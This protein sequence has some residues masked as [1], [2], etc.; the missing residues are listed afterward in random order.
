[1]DKNIYEKI[2]KAI[3]YESYH[4]SYSPMFSNIG[5]QLTN[6]IEGVGSLYLNYNRSTRSVF[7]NLIS[8]AVKMNL[9]NSTA[10]KIIFGQNEASLAFY[11]IDT[12]LFESEKLD[13]VLLFQ[14]RSENTLDL[15][16]NF[17]DDILFINGYSKNLDERD[18]DEKVGF[19]IAAK[20]IEGDLQKDT[21][22]S[23]KNK[24]KIAFTVQILE[25]NEETLVSRLNEAPNTI[26]EAM[27]KCSKWF[28]DNLKDFDI[29]L[30]TKEESDAI[31]SAV[32]GLL[33]NCTKAPGKLRNHIS[34][35]PNRGQYPTH[36]IWDS[37]FQ[38]LAYECINK[39]IAKDA[40]LQI[41]E[42]QRPDGKYPQFMC[43]TWDRPHDSQ[44]ALLGWAMKR[45]ITIIE[46]DVEFEKKVFLSMEKNNMWWLTQ[47]M[48]KYGV[49][50]CP[51]GLETGQDN[52]PRFDN[53]PTL[54]TDM[55]SFLLHQLKFTSETAL[56]FGF[57]EKAKYWENKA[58]KLEEN[59][60]KMLY[61]EEYNLFFDY[62]LTKNEP[63]KIISP[64]ALLPLWASIN[65]EEEI[66]NKMIEK[67][68]INP[69]YLFS[70]FVF[71]CIAYTEDCFDAEDWWRGPVWPSLTYLSLEILEHS[72]YHDEYMEACK[73]IHQMISEDGQ[74][75]ELFNSLTGKGMGAKSQGWTCAVFIKLCNILNK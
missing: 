53:G 2:I 12:F 3:N 34:S 61:D 21:V 16:K 67:Y 4:T 73:K 9:E 19:V 64:T 51:S 24:I 55:N 44:P 13:K 54:A 45:L 70:N 5:L 23:N 6:D 41:I 42:N 60:I 57:E 52:S 27:Q 49:I 71:P 72:K 75:S 7:E 47:R 56:K 58:K 37:Y 43:S 26:D 25:I 31:A 11:D 18:P 40:I 17:E 1:M 15:W 50:F 68:L 35:Y 32:Q 10:E 62:S 14:N 8:F 30:K 36:F 29:T 38:N 39:D 63:I 20:I 66:K 69:K 59:M 28:M 48:T 22:Y 65:I 46:K 74:M 33:F